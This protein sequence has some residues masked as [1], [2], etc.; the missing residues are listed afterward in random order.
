LD[1][2]KTKNGKFGISRDSIDNAE[3]LCVKL[4]NFLDPTPQM[5]DKGIFWNIGFRN[6]R[7]NP[8][9]GGQHE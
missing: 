1:F 3:I 9:N 7:A 8:A 5:G 6:S 4:P 2:A